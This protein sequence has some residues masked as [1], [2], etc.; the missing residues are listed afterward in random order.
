MEGL[1]SQTITLFRV[2]AVRMKLRLNVIC[3]RSVLDDKSR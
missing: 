3:K 2:E 1:L